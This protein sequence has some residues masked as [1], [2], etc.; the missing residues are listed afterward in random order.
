MLLAVEAEDVRRG[1]EYF[2]ARQPA[3]T[4]LKPLP[5]AKQVE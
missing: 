1:A 3:T 5:S 2:C 4:I